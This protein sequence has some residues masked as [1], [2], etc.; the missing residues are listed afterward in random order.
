M[1][2]HPG[3]LSFEVGP[4]PVLAPGVPFA[5]ARARAPDYG[6]YLEDFVPGAVFVH[7]RGVTLSRGLM[8]DY[9]TTFMEANPLYLNEA[10]ARAMGYRGLPAAPHLVM[11]LALSLGVQNDSEKA[12]ANLGYYDV[13]FLRPV[14]AGDVLTGLTRVA[15]RR[16]RGPKKPGIATIE[17]LAQNQ[18]G[19][20]VIQ[21]RRKV[22]VPRR[23]DA[24]IDE[25]ARAE[26]GGVAFPYAERPRIHVPRPASG[27][28]PPG[29]LTLAASRLGAFHPGDIIAHRNGRTITDEH[30][31]WTY[32]VMNTHPL[33]YDRLYS[34]AQ[35]GP[36]SGEP[37]V[38]GGLV[39]AWLLGLSSRDVTENAVWDLGY[40][41]GYHTQPTFAG[42]TVAALSRV[43]AI[44]PGPT[45]E[46][47][48]VRMQLVG[49]KNLRAEAA[50]DRF[51]EDLFVNENAKKDLGR[52]KIPDKIFEI[53]RAVLIR[54]GE[55]GA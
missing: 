15:A 7:P 8:L 44:E 23:G 49:V 50:L 53:E 26:P 39:F 11:N 45:P 21:Y 16:D 36:M 42:D 51:G 25:A 19:D 4:M 29:G 14:Y 40:H 9:A 31:G 34:Q 17:T 5:A 47:G 48:V 24:P 27:W 12:I 13:R 35:S 2:E 41:D 43:L 20:V 30:V 55:G 28:P 3:E 46:A 33:H 32:R 37:I 22:F 1:A 54:A 6:H 38:Y 52:D 10:Y 18:D